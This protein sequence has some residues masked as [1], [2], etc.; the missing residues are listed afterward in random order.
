MPIT[1]AAVFPPLFPPPRLQRPE[2]VCR[3]RLK[4]NDFR[5]RSFTFY[6]TFEKKELLKLLDF[7][8]KFQTNSIYIIVIII[9]VPKTVVC[10]ITTIIIR[11][12]NFIFL[13]TNQISVIMW[14]IIYCVIIT[15]VTLYYYYYYETNIVLTEKGNR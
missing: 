4:S 1:A 3:C 7:K 12:T 6:L 14:N 8:L 15:I 10:V 2:I 5:R 11:R 13:K 9:V